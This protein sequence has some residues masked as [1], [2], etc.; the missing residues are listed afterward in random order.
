MPRPTP[1]E[2]LSLDTLLG[3]GEKGTGT[4]WIYSQLNATAL[5]QVSATCAVV[6]TQLATVNLPGVTWKPFEAS[7]ADPSGK[8]KIVVD[9]KAPTQSI[10][11]PTTWTEVV[12]GVSHVCVGISEFVKRREALEQAAEA[13]K[14]DGSA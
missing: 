13:K 14:A 12:D 6:H 8:Y 9:P 11:S 3:T 2:K 4:S 1:R 7:N 5:K 10:V